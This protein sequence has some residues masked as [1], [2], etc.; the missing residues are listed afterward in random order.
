MAK[1]AKCVCFE[2]TH[3]TAFSHL[4]K[5]TLESLKLRA[6]KA[7]QT[8][9]SKNQVV[10]SPISRDMPVHRI[11]PFTPKPKKK[12]K[13]RHL[14]SALEMLREHAMHSTFLAIDVDGSGS[15]DPQE[16]RTFFTRI[17]PREHPNHKFHADQI[18]VCVL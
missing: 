12:I 2:L 16:M 15:V 9:E 11:S 17:F 8:G 4:P 5:S 3:E 1:S 7:L 10:L 18:N 13:H 14:K 6:E